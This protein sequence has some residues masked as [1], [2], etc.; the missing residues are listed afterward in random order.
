VVQ[1]GTIDDLTLRPADDFARRF[2]TA[3][4]LAVL[5]ERRP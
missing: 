2:V 4:R 5:P 3:Q 1:E